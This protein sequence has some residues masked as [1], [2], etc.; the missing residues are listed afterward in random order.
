MYF[1]KPGR[2]NT[3]ETLEIALETAHREGIDTIVVSSCS[4]YTVEELLK[5]GPSGVRIVCVTHVNGFLEP[6]TQEFPL[7]KRRELERKEVLFYTGT[8]VLSGGERGLSKRF[9]GVYP[10]EV[11]ANALRMLGQG[12]K[13]CVEC[14]VMALDGGLI[15][16]MRPIISIGGT[17]R[18]ADTALV[19]RTAHASNLL[20]CKIDRILCKPIL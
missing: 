8:H 7:E 11:V 13:V 20:D 12:T 2:H 10:I 14:A 4:G 5:L 19:M 1:E 17:G 18:G 16:Y 3:G 9:G 15:E 6:G